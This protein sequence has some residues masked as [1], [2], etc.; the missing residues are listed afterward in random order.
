MVLGEVI[1][2]E[3]LGFEQLDQLDALLELLRTRGAVVVEV[4]EN[5]EREHA[6]SVPGA[7]V[8]SE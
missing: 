6:D 5:T 3:A 4:I 1:A 8:S 2:V 7:I